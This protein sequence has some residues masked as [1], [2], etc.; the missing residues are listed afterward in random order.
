MS[1]VA[2]S[3]EARQRKVS[4]WARVAASPGWNAGWADWV[5]EHGPT[6]IGYKWDISDRSWPESPAEL[7]P[8]S[9]LP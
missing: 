9:T 5:R 1:F 2:G 4:A 7:K 8:D 3:P 6:V